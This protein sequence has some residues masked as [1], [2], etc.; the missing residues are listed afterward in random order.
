[1]SQQILGKSEILSS[2]IRNL[3]SRNG[4]VSSR[5]GTLGSGFWEPQSEFW[6][7]TSE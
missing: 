4:I 3:G 1:M 7:Q 5:S 2:V 6:D